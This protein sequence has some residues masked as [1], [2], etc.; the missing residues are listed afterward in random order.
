[1]DYSFALLILLVPLATFLTLGLLSNR[2]KPEVAGIIG[3]T[4][5]FII[6]I[7]S[8]YTAYKYFATPDPEEGYSSI[9]TFSILWLAFT[10]HLQIHLGI[11]LDPLS[12]M[13]LVVI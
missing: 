1:M 10:D 3:T 13:M 4:S 11:L 12:V 2:L 8:Y 9:E 5:L 7:L 6:T